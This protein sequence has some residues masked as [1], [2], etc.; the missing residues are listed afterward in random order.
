MGPM[1]FLDR[2]AEL[3]ALR[4]HLDT[5]RAELVVVYGRRRVGKSALLRAAFGPADHLYF[6]ADLG[7]DVDQRRRLAALIHQ[8]FPSRALAEPSPPSWELILEHLFAATRR[9]L[10]VVLDEFPHLCLGHKPLP[11]IL[12]RLWDEH[13]RRS[14]VCLVLCGSYVSFMEREILA[15]K[16]PLFGRRTGQL[17]LE[18]LAFSA[19]REFFPRYDAVERV[20]A[21]AVLG[22]V[23]AYL[24]QFSDAA[25][26]ERNIETA[27]LGPTAPLREEVRFVLT[28]ELRDPKQYLSV[29]EAISFGR[30]RLND[31]VQQTA[32]DRGPVSKYLAVLQE[33]RLVEREVPVTE[34]AP[35]KSRKGI[36]RI[37]DPFFRFWFRFVNAYRSELADRGPGHVL[38]AHIAANLDEFVGR[39]F[40]YTCREII[41][42]LVRSGRL[43]I[44]YDRLG[45]AWDREM[46]LDLVA[47]HGRAP[48]LVGEC[49]WSRRPVGEDILA[50]LKHKA[51]RLRRSGPLPLLALFSRSGF[52]PAVKRRERGGELLLVDVRG[53]D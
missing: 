50:G 23:P 3:D 52:T 53:L 36:Y 18:P 38:K 5:G 46:E 1:S 40:E 16:S 15:H 7:A 41:R 17:L 20:R 27:I 32:L 35:H 2:R 11:S 51:E 24:E 37:S 43:D 44:T 8:R 49:K 26:L 10:V 6:V 14:G 21:H 39:A 4:A 28:E 19:L 13:G 9:R 30:T 47:M 31:I 22:G 45:R 25:S 34:H 33:L 48:V 12:Q 29:L 42:D